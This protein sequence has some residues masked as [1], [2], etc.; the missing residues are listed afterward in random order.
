M[1]EWCDKEDCQGTLPYDVPYAGIFNREPR[2]PLTLAAPSLVSARFTIEAGS[3]NV[4]FDRSTLKGAIPKSE[5]PGD[6]LPTY[7]DYKEQ[8]VGK[9]DCSRVFDDDS[10]ALLT[11]EASRN[12]SHRPLQTITMRWYPCQ[13]CVCVSTTIYALPPSQP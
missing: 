13:K 8:L 5:I 11:E 9:F 3:I 12:V 2:I 1:V 7:V 4:N 6:V 10:A